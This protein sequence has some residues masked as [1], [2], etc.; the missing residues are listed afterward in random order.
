M[1]TALAERLLEHGCE[2]IVW[3]RTRAKAAPLLSRGAQ[4]SENPF[5]S[6]P[7]VIVSLYTTEVVKEVLDRMESGL[8]PGRI[9]LD[10]TTG[11]PAK[12]T[13]L[14]KRLAER[15]VQYLDAPIS[16]SSE[17]TRRGEATVI[18]GGKDEAFAACS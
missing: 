14:G 11:D 10:T 6:C 9:I 15:G 7:R 17:Q 16:G 3:N 2:V 4:W 12:S 1:G 13:A 8:R 5:T 18:V